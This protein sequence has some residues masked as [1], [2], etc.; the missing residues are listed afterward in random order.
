[1][2]KVR[3]VL[4]LKHETGLSVRV[5]GRSCG[6]SKS[7]VSNYVRLA[8]IQG[9]SWPLSDE[10]DDAALEK[11]L[12]PA[13]PN[14]PTKFSPLN[15]PHLNQELKHK[16]VTLALLW[17]EYRQGHIADGYGYSQ[18]CHLYRAWLGSQKRSMRQT[19]KAGEKLFV[20]YSGRTVAVVVNKLTGEFAEA[21][22]FVAV[23]GASNYTYAEAAF[24]KAFKYDPNVVEAL[25]KSLASEVIW[26][27]TSSPTTTSH[28]PVS[29]PPPGRG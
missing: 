2:P 19:H 21:Q 6:L 26:A 18:F 16:T 17:E 14:P 12:K 1:M 9:L 10:L 11:R 23:L 4:R 5:I 29:N 20:D 7:A 24:S 3:E 8:R 28:S 15:F 25:E 27:W 22:I 13:S